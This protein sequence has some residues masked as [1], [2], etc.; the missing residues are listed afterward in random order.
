[1]VL[2]KACGFGL[3]CREGAGDAVPSPV[4]EEKI[5]EGGGETVAQKLGGGGGK[6]GKKDKKKAALDDDWLEFN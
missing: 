4:V 1:M 3:V 5:R 2:C 6:K